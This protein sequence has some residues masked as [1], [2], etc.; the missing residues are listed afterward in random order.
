MICASSKYFDALCGG[1]FMEA[2]KDSAT[3]DDE[4]P[5]ILAR[6]LQACYTG[7]YG[8]E[9]QE[10]V[11]PQMI[12]NARTLCLAPS[13]DSLPE[14]DS[15][16]CVVHAKIYA[17][18]DKYDIPNL[19]RLSLSK[20]EAR[21]KDG[22]FKAVEVLEAA[23]VIYDKLPIIDD[24]LKKHVV[25]Y[26]QTHMLG[27]H[28]LPNFQELMSIPDFA[29]DFGTRFGSRGDVCC[30]ECVDRTK[31]SADC[32]C[33]FHGLCSNDV[34]T[35]QDWSALKCGKCKKKRHLLRDE[36]SDD[37]DMVMVGVVKLG[38]KGDMPATPPATPKK[39]KV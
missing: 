4:E 17:F 21:I 7:G 37:D 36:P 33:G 1:S 16:G 28:K 34:C 2:N 24:R 26:A 12:D 39:R 3:L 30:P 18:A 6:F 29:W 31:I 25:Y 15:I 38:N 9:V 32:G 19:R 13:S 23:M 35:N 27:I 5:S 22:D 10:H 8:S 11:L 14:I 20:F